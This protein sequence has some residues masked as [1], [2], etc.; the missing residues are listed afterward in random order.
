MRCVVLVSLLVLT[1]CDD[2]AGGGADAAAP[3]DAG[4]SADASGGGDA[5]GGPDAGAGRDAGDDA[6]AGASDAGFDAGSPVGSAGCGAPADIATAEWVERTASVDG[7]SRTW[8][9]WLPEGYDAGRAYPVVYQWHGCSGAETRENNHPP[10]QRESGA[11]AILVRGR[12]VERCWDT[13]P[14]GPDVAFFDA[15]VAE[16]EATWCANPERRFATGYSSGAFM[17]HQLACVRGDQLT[18]VASIAGGNAGRSCVGSVGALL[19]HD[20]EDLTVNVMASEG[21]RDGHLA[22]NGCGDTTTPVDPSPCVAYDGCDMPVVWCETMGSGHSRQ[23][24]L[25]A[26]AFWGFLSSF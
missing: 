8:F 7:V 24:G 4:L 23:D 5:G 20:R 12:A 18:A 21:A 10:L 25:S 15:L 11:D 13:S 2:E 17:T 16:V 19:I 26:P 6:D 3:G 9:V 22:R 1:G 14:G